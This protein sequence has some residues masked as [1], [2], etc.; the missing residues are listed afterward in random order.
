M[1][2]RNARISLD[3]IGRGEVFI[4]GQK[5]RGVRGLKLEGEVGDL[6]RLVLDVVVHE[7]EVDGETVVTVPEKTAETLKRLGWM[8]PAEGG[9]GA[10]A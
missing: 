4:D 2:A 3:K 6:P 9:D 1:S 5:V 7:A 8:P 10:A